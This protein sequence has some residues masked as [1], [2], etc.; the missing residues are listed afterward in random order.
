M[1]MTILPHQSQMDR[2]AINNERRAR[3]YLQNISKIEYELNE[4]S[5]KL[6]NARRAAQIGDSLAIARIQP[7]ERR[8][9]EVQKELDAAKAAFKGKFLTEETEADYLSDGDTKTKTRGK[10]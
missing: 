10:K 4:L 5:V 3:A 9:E 1:D 8:V 2:N 6:R 7:L